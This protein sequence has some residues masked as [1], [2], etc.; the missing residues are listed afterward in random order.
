MPTEKLSMMQKRDLLQQEVARLA[1]EHGVSLNV[2]YWPIGELVNVQTELDREGLMGRPVRYCRIRNLSASTSDT[3]PQTSGT[4]TNWQNAN[5]K[6]AHRFRV[7]LLYEWEVAG[8]YAASSQK[9]WDDLT[10]SQAL[11]DE[12]D[13][14][15]GILPF[16]RQAPTLAPAGSPELTCQCTRPQNETLPNVPQWQNELEL[17]THYLS[18]ELGLTG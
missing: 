18:F 1:S 7:K 14:P 2:V 6:T 16:F 12:F 3:E 4:N 17:Y 10:E 11:D 13:L 8:S 15:I 9:G 5:V